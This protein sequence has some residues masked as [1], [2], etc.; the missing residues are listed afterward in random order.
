MSEYVK[1]L[2]RRY[3]ERKKKLEEIEIQERKEYLASIF[4][5]ME[6]S[7][8]EGKDR[9]YLKVPSCHY[10]YAKRYLWAISEIELLGFKITKEVGHSG[11]ELGCWISW[12]DEVIEE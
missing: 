1:E 4:S 8:D 3:R 5:L 6:T 11:A 7:A 10:D 9:I 2:N 12:A